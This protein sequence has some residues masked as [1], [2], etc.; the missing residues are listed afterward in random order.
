MFKLA[1]KDVQFS[2]KID[3]FLHKIRLFYKTLHYHGHTIARFFAQN[4]RIHGHFTPPQKLHSFLFAQK[5]EHF[6]RLRSRE[7]ILGEKE[8]PHAITSLIA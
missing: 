4:V 6:L 3:S 2:V 8:H 5:L 1:A 7:L